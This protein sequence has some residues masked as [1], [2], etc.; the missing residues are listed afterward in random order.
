MVLKYLPNAFSLTRLLLIAPFLMYLHQKQY[1]AALYIFIFAGLT[2]GLDGW[3]A[4]LFDWQTRFGSF[5]DPVADKLLIASSF[6]S[7]AFIGQLPWWLV[8][9]VFFRD[10][11]IS[12]GVMAWQRFIPQRLDF[13]PTWLS[14]INTVLQLTLVIFCLVELAFDKSLP[15][16]TYLLIGLTTLTTSATYIDYVWTGARKA[17]ASTPIPQ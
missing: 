13:K 15:E 7:L 17:Y 14:K 4:R 16:V 9:L 8:S 10:L 11:T 12:L 1:A 2:D 6:V 3:L 5:I